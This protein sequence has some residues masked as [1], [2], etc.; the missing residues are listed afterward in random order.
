MFKASQISKFCRLVG[1]NT[2]DKNKSFYRSKTSIPPPRSKRFFWR[3]VV[4]ERD[5]TAAAA[6]GVNNPHLT[7][8]EA[9]SQEY[10]YQ[11]MVLL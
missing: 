11:R 8:E 4:D 9:D 1:R 2:T 5:G 7:R 6:V 10:R 3:L